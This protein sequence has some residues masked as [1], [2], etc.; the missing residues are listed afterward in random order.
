[1]W[2][3]VSYSPLCFLFSSVSPPLS[4]SFRFL[5][6]TLASLSSAR[7]ALY[8]ITLVT[9]VSARQGSL[10]R[11]LGVLTS[12]GRTNR[13]NSLL[14]RCSPRAACT[15]NHPSPTQWFHNCRFYSLLSLSLFLILF[16]SFIYPSIVQLFISSSLILFLCNFC[17]IFRALI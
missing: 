11:S 9:T 15:T 1:M 4:I 8:K 5:Q 10:I 16:V 7:T 12:L 2:S 17:A 6:L 3:E 14:S 13:F